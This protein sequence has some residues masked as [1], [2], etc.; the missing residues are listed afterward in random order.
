MVDD[1]VVADAIL[2]GETTVKP[3]PATAATRNRPDELASSEKS[4]SNAW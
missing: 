4:S 3:V 1:V 2:S